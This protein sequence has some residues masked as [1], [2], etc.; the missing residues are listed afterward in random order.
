MTPEKAPQSRQLGTPAIIE[1]MQLTNEI[2]Y[3]VRIQ[4]EDLRAPIIEFGGLFKHWR[5]LALLTIPPSLL[6]FVPGN[7]FSTPCILLGGFGMMCLV[8]R[9]VQLK[10]HI[11]KTLKTP[12][13]DGEVT[14]T[15]STD[16]FRQ[17]SENFDFNAD[18]SQFISW[19]EAGA[20][21]ILFTSPIQF[22]LI[23]RRCLSDAQYNEVREFVASKL[24]KRDAPKLDKLVIPIA[25]IVVLMEIGLSTLSIVM[26]K[27][28]TKM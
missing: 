18:W 19:A 5:A 24:P 27:F 8:W 12:M 17:H 20:V 26:T 9:Y 6:G 23:V 22:H 1:C 2:T 14:Y 4:E 15:L 13:Y 11:E 7:F 25:V 3:K 10:Q 28:G 21:L 16:R